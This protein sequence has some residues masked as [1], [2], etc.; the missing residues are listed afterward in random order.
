[1]NTLTVDSVSNFDHAFR[2]GLSVER[3]RAQAPAAFAESPFGKVSP[4]YRFISTRE[5]VEAL[6]DAGFAATEARQARARGERAGYARHLLRFRPVRAEVA[7]DEAIPEIIVVN[8]HDGTSAYQVRAGLFRP[9]CTNGLMTK[10]GDFGVIYV[11]HRGNVVA[12]VV[13]AATRILSQF[14]PV[15]GAVKGMAATHLSDRAQMEFAE[16][17]VSIRWR[18]EMPVQPRR[19]LEVRRPADVGD[20]LWR[21]FNTVQENVIRGGVTS[22]AASGRLGRTRGIR[23]IKEDVRINT[24]LWQAAVD[25]IVN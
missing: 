1:M 8:A 22:R 17:A 23:A 2:P 6:L 24:Q 15:A 25:R 16:Q 10:L 12:N 3:L 19:L 13:E 18:R 20:D 7:L 5:L 21:V 9:V 14:E 11:P 4:A